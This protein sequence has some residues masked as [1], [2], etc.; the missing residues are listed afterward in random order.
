MDIFAGARVIRLR[1]AY[2]KYLVAKED[3][4]R[5]G[6]D[7]DGFSD[8]ARWTV[9]IIANEQRLRLRSSWNRYLA[10]DNKTVSQQLPDRVGARGDWQPLDVG[11]HV[12]LRCNDVDYLRAQE[13]HLPWRG[14]VTLR[15][16]S[17]QRSRTPFYWD[18]EILEAE[19][20]PL[21]PPPQAEAPAPPSM[22]ARPSSSSVPAGPSDRSNVP[23]RVVTGAAE[24]SSST[25][26][27]TISSPINA[28]AASS[29]TASLVP[30]AVIHGAAPALPS[31]SSYSRYEV[32]DREINYVVAEES[33]ILTAAYARGLTFTGT[34]SSELIRRLKEQIGIEDIYVCARN[35]H[36]QW[37]MPLDEELP[38][39]YELNNYLEV[40]MAVF[41]NRLGETFRTATAYHIRSAHVNSYLVAEGDQLRLRL[42][43]S[44]I[45]ARWTIEVITNARNQQRIRF[46]SCFGWCLS[47]SLTWYSLQRLSSEDNAVSPQMVEDIEASRD[48]WLPF[49]V[50]NHFMFRCSLD[51]FLAAGHPMG[52]NAVDDGPTFFLF[53]TLDS[54]MCDIHDILPFM[55]RI[56][57]SEP[58]SPA[59]TDPDA[60]E[61][62][63]GPDE[64]P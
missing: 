9:E 48:E 53:N 24:A 51:D 6:M 63:N 7:Q 45:G 23:I 43:G 28:A 42:D 62:Q 11:H 54:F 44:S 35:Y 50:W 22:A 61:Q 1:S 16:P 15:T 57:A 25:M 32:M 41:P 55:W 13:R 33:G 40:F 56:E 5:V 10:A 38:P 46:R 37:L 31:S 36:S 18:V 17:W 64:T 4:T 19:H 30:S 59:T 21:L 8:G 52:L 12:L 49:P 3:T 34:S 60:L 2:Q 14:S 39:L 47:A 20:L 29:A 26:P 58:T 27:A